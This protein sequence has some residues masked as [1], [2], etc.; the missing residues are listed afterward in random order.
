LEDDHDAGYQLLS[1]IGSDAHPP[2]SRPVSTL[3]KVDLKT[4]DIFSGAGWWCAAR[5]VILQPN[6]VVNREKAQTFSD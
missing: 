2:F 5:R 1:E 6:C 3:V 4:L